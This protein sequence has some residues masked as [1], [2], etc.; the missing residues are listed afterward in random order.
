[1]APKVLPKVG[2]YN[3]LFIFLND[4]LPNTKQEIKDYRFSSEFLARNNNETEYSSTVNIF[5]L[6]KSFVFE[7][8][9]INFSG[10]FLATT[11]KYFLRS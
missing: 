4:S 11:F 6:D 2:D 7:K 10:W 9:I 1:M 5:Y 3:A 8:Q